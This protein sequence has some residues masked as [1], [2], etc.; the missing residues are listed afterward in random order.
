MEFGTQPF[1]VPRRE[2]IST[3]TMFG[4]PTYRWLSAKSKITTHFVVFYTH[5]PEGL[6]KV[7]DVRIEN[8]QIVIE[9]HAA[10][11]QVR[12]AATTLN[13]PQASANDHR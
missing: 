7:D 10:H 12:L 2:A 8:G 9:D 1:D 5:V 13:P 6:Q 3:G 4:A 11:K